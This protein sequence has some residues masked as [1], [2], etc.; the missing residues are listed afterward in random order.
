MEKT[1]MTET[2]VLLSK[3]AALRQ[4]LDQARGPVTPSALV[5][6]PALARQVALGGEHDQMIEQTV[7]DVAGPPEAE[8]GLLPRR[9]TSRARRVLEQG[10]E[11]L[12]KLRGMSDAFT[13]L[14]GEPSFEAPTGWLLDRGSPLA[15]FYRETVAIIDATLRMIPSLPDTTASQL[16]LSEGME[17]ILHVVGQRLEILTDGVKQHQQEQGRITSLA[18][19]FRALGHGAEVNPE[20]FQAAALEIHADALQC[21][22]LQLVH[23]EPA[24]PERYAAARGLSVARVVARVVRHEPELRA[25]AL[26][27]IL[28]GLLL[29]IGLVGLPGSVLAQEGPLSDEQRRQ[30]EGHCRAGAELVEKLLPGAAWLSDAVLSHH[31][32]LD[33]T[34]YPEGRKHFQQPPLTRLLAVCDVYTALCSPR[35]HRPARDPRTALTDTL[36]LAEQGLLDQ[37]QAERLLHLSFYPIGSAVEMVD[38]SVAVVVAVPP[39]RRDLNSPARPVV[40]VLLDGEGRALSR[41]RHLDLG[42]CE[43][44]SIVRT[45]SP[46]ERRNLLGTRF[47]EWA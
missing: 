29:D 13:P 45:L 36:L 24:Q 4:R 5:T 41:P 28:A 9:L 34:G 14:V 43:G 38:G 27:A 10:R 16:S 30:I 33:G 7:R 15:V 25:R 22:P 19:L 23:A 8:Q 18:E 12:A 46:T 40:A 35:P 31:E 44:H 37:Q 20:P 2:Q 32:R 17:G 11:L 26:D 6:V 1:T 47:P 42:Q 39:L 3:I 21:G